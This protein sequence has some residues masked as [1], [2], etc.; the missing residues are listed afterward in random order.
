MAQSGLGVCRAT[1][2]F[3][4]PPHKRENPAESAKEVHNNPE[5]LDGETDSALQVHILEGGLSLHG[6]LAPPEVLPLQRRLVDRFVIMKQSVRE[7][8]SP[9]PSSRGSPGAE[10]RRPSILRWVG[11]LPA[12]AEKEMEETRTEG[13]FRCSLMTRNPHLLTIPTSL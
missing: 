3:F 2:N 13:P 8:A 12:I 7:A 5:A 11:L 1:R 10:S 4:V 9:G 6:R